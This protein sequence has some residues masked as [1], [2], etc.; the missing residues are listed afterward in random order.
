LG[1]C[2]LTSECL[3]KIGDLTRAKQII[4][5]QIAL[6]PDEPDLWLTLARVE[7]GLGNTGAAKTAVKGYVKLYPEGRLDVIDLDGI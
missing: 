7:A 6:Y 5:G 2:L 3:L 1:V 4:D